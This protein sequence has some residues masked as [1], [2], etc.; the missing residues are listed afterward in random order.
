MSSLPQSPAP[1]DISR[2]Q[3]DS[4]SSRLIPSV[5]DLVRDAYRKNKVLSNDPDR[6]LLRTLLQQQL[7]NKLKKI[8]RET[9]DVD[10]EQGLPFVGRPINSE[11]NGSVFPSLVEVV[12]LPLLLWARKSVESLLLL[13]PPLPQ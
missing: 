10:E 1:I 13:L 5:C 8:F 9:G 6:P 4:A 11:I 12:P 7:W 3:A 2:P